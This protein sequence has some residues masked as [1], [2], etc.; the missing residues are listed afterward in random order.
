[1][2]QGPVGLWTELPA[3][4]AYFYPTHVWVTEEGHAG[5]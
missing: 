4:V 2:N 1:M 3:T 5:S